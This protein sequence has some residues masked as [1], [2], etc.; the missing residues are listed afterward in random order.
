MSR[1]AFERIAEGLEQGRRIV[2][3]EEARGTR[4]HVRKVDRSEVAAIRIREGLTQGEFARLIGTSIG[5][6]RKWETGERL[7]S[8]PAST[9]LRVLAYD[10]DVVAKAVGRKPKTAKRQPRSHLIGID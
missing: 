6:V 5:T 1:T 10:A 9:L 3:G 2:R 7:P 4:V 8:G